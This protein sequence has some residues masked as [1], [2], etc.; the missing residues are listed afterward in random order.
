VIFL[1]APFSQKSENLASPKQPVFYL[2]IWVG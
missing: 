2:E 1:L